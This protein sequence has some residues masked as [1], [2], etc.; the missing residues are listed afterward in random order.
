MPEESALHLEI[1]DEI[2]ATDALRKLAAI[3]HD[4]G[5]V[6]TH[7]FFS[8]LADELGD[9]DNALEWLASLS[10]EIDR[11]IAVNLPRQG[12][13]T[14]TV[15][16]PPSWSAQRLRDWVAR[17]RGF[18]EAEFGAI[19]SIASPSGSA[20][21]RPLLVAR[22]TPGV[23][24]PS[25]DE[26]LVRFW[27]G[28]SP[29]QMAATLI[30][31][32]ISGPLN[33]PRRRQ[34]TRLVGMAS[35]AD[36]TLN[37]IVDI[38]ET[39]ERRQ[40]DL[41]FGYDLAVRS[42]AGFAA[43]GN[44]M[45]ILLPRPPDDELGDFFGSDGIITPTPEQIDEIYR[46][47]VPI[48]RVIGITDAHTIGTDRPT[49]VVWLDASTRPDIADL[50]RV[51]QYEPGGGDTEV[52]W[53]LLFRLEEQQVVLMCEFIR[54][55]HTEFSV[56]FSLPKHLSFLEEV[57][58]QNQL[59]I[60]VGESPPL[61]RTG[62]L[63][64]EER[65]DLL[66]RAI[67]FVGVTTEQLSSIL[68]NWRQ[69]YARFYR[70]PEVDDAETGDVPRTIIEI[71]DRMP[72]EVRELWT[73]DRQREFAFG[74]IVA[75]LEYPHRSLGLDDAVEQVDRAVVVGLAQ[76]GMPRGPLRA[77]VA[78]V[79]RSLGHNA[80]KLQDCSLVVSSTY[81][82]T[83]KRLYGTVD[84]AFRTWV[85][86][87][88]HARQPY[89]NGFL[90][91]WEAYEGYEEGMADGLSGLLCGWARMETLTTDYEAYVRGYAALAKVLAV[92]LWSLL[93]PLWDYPMGRVRFGLPRVVALRWHQ[94]M[95][96]EITADREQALLRAGDRVFASGRTRL[97]LSDS[98]LEELWRAALL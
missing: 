64:D 43:A 77:P 68:R 59:M 60:G 18:L 62:M 21:D 34:L 36:A 7:R 33:A 4:L 42:G 53:G 22:L 3:S 15:L 88:I 83:L 92:P 70:I 32:D 63:S 11:P 79:P 8:R 31:C 97:D 9:A 56:L 65:V 58:R 38:S 17:R 95:G 28:A 5:T 98:D 19:G 13:S 82:R 16:A 54:P 69:D 45:E 90:D 29:E 85:H 49:P 87:S 27:Q 57:V 84:P 51:H 41:T 26:T 40:A 20:A 86:E 71:T 78:V 47:S 76:F 46:I 14:T 75:A 35:K 24:H 55:V 12:T 52:R 89:A 10:I 81:L 6:V 37:C 1:G 50:P 44:R 74:E 91:E 72:P 94:L 96:A 25:L 73:N 48:R 39:P 23:N 66:Q 67:V 30:D 80:I 61:G 93:R 2:P